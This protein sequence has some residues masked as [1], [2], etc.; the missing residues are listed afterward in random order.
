MNLIFKYISK[1]WIIIVT[2]ILFIS[3]SNINKE[4][5][6]SPPPV[7]KGWGDRFYPEPISIGGNNYYIQH[8][9]PNCPAINTGVQRGYYKITKTDNIFCHKCMDDT[10]ITIFNM[11]YF[12]DDK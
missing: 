4:E 12:P 2:S 7:I 8:S 5:P 1:T 11:K 6:K 10:L 9:T 3:C